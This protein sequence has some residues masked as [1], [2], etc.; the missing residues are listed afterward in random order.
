MDGPRLPV[1]LTKPLSDPAKMR[2]VRRTLAS[3]RLSTVCDEARC[4]NRVEC[5]ARRTAT[6]MILGDRC[7][8]DCRFCAVSHGLPDPPDS[9]EPRRIAAAARELGLGFVVLTSVTRDDLADGGGS[10]FAATVRALRSELPDSGIEV[11]VP[12]FRGNGA[13]LDTVLE[14]EPDVL[15]HNVETVS[16]L[17]SS[18]RCGADYERSLDV[19]SRAAASSHRAHV[20]SAIMLGLGEERREVESTL[21]DLRDAGAEFLCLGQYLRP[22]SAHAPVVRFVPPAEFEEL[23]EHALS[24]GFDWVSAGPFVRSSYRAETAV[25]VAGRRS[26]GA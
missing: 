23:R 12:D 18:V 14:S 22:S 17:Y 2:A 26:G 4:P 8:R 9:D 25:E 1:W 13:A 20:K 5:F 7:T 19:I 15:G 24:L 3:N 21:C 6:F 10:H 16:R 11:L